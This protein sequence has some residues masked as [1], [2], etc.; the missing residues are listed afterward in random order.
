MAATPV[1]NGNPVPRVKGQFWQPGTEIWVAA[2]SQDSGVPI[3]HDGTLDLDTVYLKAEF[4]LVADLF[5][6]W[7]DPGKGDDPLTD[8]RTPPDPNP[9]KTAV[10]V[11]IP[12]WRF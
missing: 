7:T 6:S 12:R 8:F 1:N 4:P 2:T 3:S 11:S 9:A 5:A 10:G